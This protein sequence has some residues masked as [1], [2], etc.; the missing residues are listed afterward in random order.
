MLIRI[1]KECGLSEY[2]RLKMSALTG[3]SRLEPDADNWTLGAE[4]DAHSLK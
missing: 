3:S 4:F 2:P 1:A